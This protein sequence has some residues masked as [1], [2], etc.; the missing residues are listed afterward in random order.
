[1]T[2]EEEI[3]KQIHSMGYVTLKPKKVIPS[4]YK[5]KDGSIIS[6]LINPNFFLQINE[7]VDGFGGG[8]TN[9]VSVFVPKEMRKPE[10]FKSLSPNQI[11]AGITDTDVSFT[12]ILE[13]FN[14]YE[15]SNGMILSIKTIVSQIKKTKFYTAGGEPVYEVSTIPAVKVKNTDS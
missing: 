5:L 6:A 12:P 10:E 8:S 1:M 4:Y 15:M 14:E 11:S 3:I 13:E 2:N 7:S 9:I